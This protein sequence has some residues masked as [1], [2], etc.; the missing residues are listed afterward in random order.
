MFV[1]FGILQG[2]GVSICKLY[3]ILMTKWLG[4]KPYKALGANP[5]YHA[6]A[7]GLTFTWFTFTLLWFW[8]NW[9]DIGFMFGALGTRALTVSW[10][11]LF[12]GATLVLTAWEAIRNLSLAF[13]WEKEPLLLSRYARTVWA[14]ALVFVLVAVMELMNAPA[15]D[16]VYKTF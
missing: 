11:L 8:S 10:L 6:I 12:I 3:Q 14:T 13:Q 15:P 16:I 1:F 5:V 2:G 7:R 9:R 4:R